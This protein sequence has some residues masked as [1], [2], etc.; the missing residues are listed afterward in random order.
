MSGFIGK[1]SPEIKKQ[2]TIED[3]KKDEKDEKKGKMSGMFGKKSP[4]IKKQ[5]T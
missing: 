5:D 1:K 4:E 2:D 3:E